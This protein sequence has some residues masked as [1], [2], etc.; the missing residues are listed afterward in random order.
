LTAVRTIAGGAN[1]TVAVVDPGPDEEERARIRVRRLSFVGQWSVGIAIIVLWEVLTR[2]KLVDPYYFSSPLLIAQTTIKAWTAGTLPADIAY[3]SG[4]TIVGFVV[5]VTGGALIGLSMWWSRVYGNVLEPY[6]VTFNAVPKLALAPVLVI[7]FG[8]GFSSKIALATAMCL[9]P[10][11]IAAYS[12]VRSIDVDMETLL[13]SLGAKRRHVFTK[14]AVPWAMPW[15]V[16]SL[17]INIGLALA[18]TIVGEFVASQ[19]GLGRMV[20][21]AGQVMDIN[22]VWVGVVMLSLLAMAMYVVVSYLEKFLL[23]GMMH[24]AQTAGR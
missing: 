19:N 1:A 3:T 17:R 16:S 22:L 8:I 12:G 4:A 18:G 13:F 5:G 11:A 14:V 20:L 9:V 10:T 2:L 15:I 23:K 6:L 21:Y 7:L 24:G